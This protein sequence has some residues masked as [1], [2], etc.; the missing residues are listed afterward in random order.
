MGPA[1]RLPLAGS[2]RHCP[3]VFVRPQTGAAP[4]T[5]RVVLTTTAL[6]DNEYLGTEREYIRAF[7]R[8]TG[9]AVRIIPNRES[10]VD[11]LEAY[12]HWFSE[13][14]PVP[15]VLRLD[16]I[17]PGLLADDLTDLKALLGEQAELYSLELIRG[18]TVHGRLVALP[19]ENDVGIACFITARTC[20]PSTASGDRREPGLSW[21]AWPKAFRPASGAKE[22]R[23]SGVTFGKEL[24]TKG[25]PATQWSGKGVVR[26][27]AGSL[28][29][30]ARSW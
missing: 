19:L 20:L 25:S 1:R 9:I 5:E 24:R 18:G 22:T 7:T 12:R 23:H 21:S 8:E 16:V 10:D 6:L 27:A 28:M 2:Y 17:W 13:R 11:Q 30:T 14:S 29:R 26:A 4:A 15:D 3:T